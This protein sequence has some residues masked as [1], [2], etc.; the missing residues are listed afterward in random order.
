MLQDSGDLAM[1]L[2][3]DALLLSEVLVVDALFNDLL[4]DEVYHAHVHIQIDQ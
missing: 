2:F 1:S 3:S 4:V